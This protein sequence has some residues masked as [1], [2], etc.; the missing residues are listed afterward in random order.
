[1]GLQNW[2]VFREAVAGLYHLVMP[3]S[4]LE[5]ALTKRAA[6]LFLRFEP[7]KSSQTE[8]LSFALSWATNKPFS[9]SP[10]SSPCLLFLCLLLLCGELRLAVTMSGQPGKKMK[11]MVCKLKVLKSM[12]FKL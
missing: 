5:S 4:M 10:P 9:S 6:F 3:R 1:M 7:I 11:S 2:S 12:V 8:V